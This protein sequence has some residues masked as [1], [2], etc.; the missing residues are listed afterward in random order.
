MVDQCAKAS[1]ACN[2][3]PYQS[4][5]DKPE[6]GKYCTSTIPQWRY[7]TPLIRN[8]PVSYVAH[9]KLVILGVMTLDSSKSRWDQ[10]CVH[11]D[12]DKE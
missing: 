1:A 3:L 11:S 4:K 12:Y 7:S 6:A 5:H 2:N 9:I 10:F 8:I